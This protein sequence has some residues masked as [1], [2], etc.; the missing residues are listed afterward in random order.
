M[1]LSKNTLA[2]AAG[3]KLHFWTGGGRACAR[4]CL[5]T[6]TCVGEHEGAIW[7]MAL[8]ADRSALVS[9]GSDGLVK[10]WPLARD[11]SDAVALA[12]AQPAV[13]S[14]NHDDI[15]SIAVGSARRLQRRSTRCCPTSCSAAA[16]TAPSRSGTASSASACRWRRGGGVRRRTTPRTASRS[17]RWRAIPRGT[18]CS[19]GART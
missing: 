2:V 19:R 3:R 5:D 10:V 17:R 7:D 6:L 14:S 8:T 9:G 16:S 1:P 12:A 11:V 4:S 18:C 13:L 15:Y